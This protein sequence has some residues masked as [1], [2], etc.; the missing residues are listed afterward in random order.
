MTKNYKAEFGFLTMATPNDY[1]K[2]I[3]LALSL[4]CSNPSIPIAVACSKKVAPLVEKYFDYVVEEKAGLRG[5]VHKIYMD[6]YTPFKDT[7]FFDSD[8]LVFKPV[9]PIVESW[10]DASYYACGKFITDGKSTFGLE[11]SRV[12]ALT[13]KSKMVDI[14]G[15][16]HALFRMPEAQKVFERAREITA[17]YKNIAGDIP[18]ADEDVI[19]IVMTEFDMSPAPYGE[20]FA[21]TIGAKFGTLKMNAAKAQCSYVYIGDNQ[22]H[23]PCMIHFAANEAPILYSWELFKLYKQFSVPSDGLL[24]LCV[25]DFYE[26]YIKLTI[27]KYKRRLFRL[28]GIHKK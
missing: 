22:R 7:V 21:R 18:Y 10:G 4:R 6:E 12:L 17:D 13:G 5:F 24:K 9:K 27:S 16:G 8:I 3:G 14:G 26:R 19:N 25:E 11:T 20:F 2:A 28:L 1:L 15:A 23:E